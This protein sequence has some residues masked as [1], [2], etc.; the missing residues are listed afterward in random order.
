MSAA[1]ESTTVFPVMWLNRK[2]SIETAASSFQRFT[3]AP[4]SYLSTVT[5][6]AD[7]SYLGHDALRVAA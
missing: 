1:R 3:F 5:P 2:K 4:R 6:I 7:I